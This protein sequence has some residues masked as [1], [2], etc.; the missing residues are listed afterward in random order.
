MH[1]DVLVIV[2]KVRLLPEQPLQVLHP[3]VSDLFRGA[4]ATKLPGSFGVVV[5]APSF[6]VGSDQE[7]IRQRN[8]AMH[9]EETDRRSVR[10]FTPCVEMLSGMEKAF[11]ALL[12]MAHDGRLEHAGAY[13]MAPADRQKRA[14]PGTLRTQ[15]RKNRYRHSPGAVM[16][17]S[18][19]R[20]CVSAADR[21]V[22]PDFTR[23]AIPPQT[24]YAA[25]ILV[26]SDTFL[27][28]LIA[29]SAEQ[30]ASIEPPDFGV[31]AADP[32]PV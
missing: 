21:L 5:A 17:T 1:I 4:P 12:I 31:G 6:S 16:P 25:S 7:G 23:F 24:E 27:V 32:P 15:P 28:D 9:R 20:I 11:R 19:D 18:A 10:I 30:H 29:A 13:T 22:S 14:L 3:R 8:A 2:R 26:L